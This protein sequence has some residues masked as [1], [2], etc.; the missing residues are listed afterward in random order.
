VVEERG[1][2]VCSTIMVG[3][4]CHL[5][6]DLCCLDRD[7]TQG[8]FPLPEFTARVDGP[9]TLVHFLT[10]VNSG[11]VHGHPVTP[12]YTGVQFPRP[13]LTG[14]KKCTRVLGPSTLAVNSGSGNRPSV[15]SI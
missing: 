1:E 13:E 9:R 6:S 14:V 3:S 4:L 2:D 12:V 11:S 5:E 7:T 8:R 15:T 10:P